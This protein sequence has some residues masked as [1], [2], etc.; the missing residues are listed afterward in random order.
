MRSTITL[1]HSWTTKP[2]ARLLDRLAPP[3]AL[4]LLAIAVAIGL[5]TGYGAVLFIGAL[6]LV[7]TWAEG[8]RATYGVQGM[9]LALGIGGAL[10]APLVV[11]LASEARGHG[12]PEV[13]EAIAVRGGRIRPRVAVVKAVASAL[14]IGT[15]GS[16]GRE[17]PIVQIGSALGSTVGQLLAFSEERIKILVAAGAASGIAAT[18]NAPI[19]GVIFALEVILG[20]FSMGYFGIVVIAAVSASIVSQAHLGSAPAFIV[21]A[22]GLGSP[23]ELGLYVLVGLASALLAIFFIKILYTAE[24]L[25]EKWRVP[26]VLKPVVGMLLTG[27]VALFY[28]QVLGPGLEFIGEAI[29][30]NMAMSLTLLA[31]LAVAKLV[32]TSFTL[33]A[34]NS[35][36]VFAPSLFAGAALGG[37]LGLVF[38]EMFPYL[39]INPGAY[40]LV[41]MAATFAGAARAP[42]TAI[43]IVF[44]M[45]ND[46]RL[47][48]PLMLATVISTFFA[49]AIHQESIYTLKLAR[50]G[51]VIRHGR[52]ID[53]MESITVKQAMQRSPAVVQD[54]LPVSELGKAFA[55]HHVHGFPVVDKDGRLVG[56][57]ALSDYERATE[58]PDFDQLKVRDIMTR[59]V[60]VV[61]PDESLWEALRKLGVRDVSRLPVVSRRDPRKLLGIIRRRDIIRA[62]NVAVARRSEIQQRMQELH[63]GSEGETEYVRLELPADAWAVGKRVSELP[64]PRECVLVSVR[65]GREV[66]IPHGDTLLQPGDRIT[67]FTTRACVPVVGSL[68]I[69]GPGAESGANTSKE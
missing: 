37:S 38:R 64:L 50:R 52:D 20:E 69:E 32:A 15:G 35:G 11:Y 19:A 54:D 7:Q 17:G 4:V 5:L 6:H 22:Y 40:A 41:G 42:I 28:P 34:G 25:F 29:A 43:L 26:E 36:G 30:E 44:E 59:D 33:G 65:R 16:A 53:I 39:G 14:T 66:I 47:I 63:M 23:V 51:I 49:H 3:P 13:M 60:I 57:V 1:L 68:L 9:F 55:A 67:I 10:G 31:P 12:V 21:P 27:V 2:L 62:Y 58:R 56:I 8:L 61:Y 18:F 46:Y 45:S 24:D 48:L